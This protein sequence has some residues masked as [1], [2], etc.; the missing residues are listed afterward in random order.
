MTSSIVHIGFH[1]TGTTWFQQC[2]YPRVKNL[3]YVPRATTQLALLM[4]SAYAFDPARAARELGV[5]SGPLILCEENLS[6]YPHN[7]GLHGFLTRAVAERIHAVLPDARVVVFVRAQPEMIAACYQQYVRGGGTHSAQRYLWP[8][9]WLR[10]AEALPFKAP[11]FSFDH[12]EYDRV[13]AHYRALFGRERVHV[14]PFEALQRDTAGLL[15]RFAR[16]LGLDLD[17]ASVPLAKRNPSYSPSLLALMRVLNRFTARTVQDKRY[18]VH[19][20]RWYSLRRRLIEPLNRS[21]L[22]GARATVESVL[23]EPAVAWI[24]Q[25]FGESN[26]RL[27]ALVPFDL[28]ALGYPFDPP[29]EPAERPRRAA[30]RRS[31]VK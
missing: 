23:G 8:G 16:E 5:A 29:A 22:L 28:E 9:D 12:F 27:A 30:W 6:G 13:V 7:G 14:F 3:R 31:L 20:P 17:L 4:P 10:G 18:W 15:A 21:G 24:R 25:R 26:R 1:K 11:R 19:L 2:V